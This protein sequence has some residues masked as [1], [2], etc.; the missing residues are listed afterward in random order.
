MATALVLIPSFSGRR[1]FT[2]L[3]YSLVLRGGLNPFFFRSSFIPFRS[4]WETGT[5][6]E[7]L[8]PSFSGRRSFVDALSK[9]TKSTLPS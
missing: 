8:I 7:V 9:V 2:L 3:S 4:G 6:M 1:S 5:V